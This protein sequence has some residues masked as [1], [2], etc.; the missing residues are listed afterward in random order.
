M[1]KNILKL[2]KG[3]YELYF[4]GDVHFPRGKYNL[5]TQ[6]IK[7]IAEKPYRKMIG[8]GDWI[9]G[10][11]QN[12]KRYNP[13]EISFMI[14]KYGTDVNM[15]NTQYHYIEN[16][17]FPLV[18]NQQIIGLHN[19]NH[20]LYNIKQTSS[21]ELKNM[22]RRLDTEF[23]DSG[24]AITSLINQDNE[25]NILS[26]HGIGGG[27][28]PGYAIN[29][30]DKHSNIFSDIDIIAEGHTHKL[31]LNISED[32]LDHRSS[33]NLK[34]TPQY[35]MAC[36]SFLGNYDYG[37]ASYAELKMYKPLPLGNMRVDIE[38]CKIKQVSAIV[39]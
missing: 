17:L 3:L 11:I 18:K 26:A 24:C 31:S 39:L 32:R 1:K 16:A 34:H 2:D 12:D 28:L 6:V 8:L 14:E 9:E 15:I 13:E 33:K 30:L 22:C 25:I 10:I 27:I 37:Y 29:Q 23:Y 5:F 21:D 38:D 35:H 36:G 19:G 4:L 7:H 20:E